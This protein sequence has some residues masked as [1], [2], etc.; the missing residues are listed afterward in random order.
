VV[1]VARRRANAATRVA[2]FARYIP[3][4]PDT[5][6]GHE[7]NAHLE[8]LKTFSFPKDSNAACRIKRGK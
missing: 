5:Y 2:V 4:S 3:F 8:K 6:Q 1:Q 7:A